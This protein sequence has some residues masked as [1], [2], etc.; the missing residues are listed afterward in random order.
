MCSLFDFIRRR[1]DYKSGF[2]QINILEG[3]AY[4]VLI[5][6]SH[7]SYSSHW[8]TNVIINNKCTFCIFRRSELP[9]KN[10]NRFVSVNC[11]VQRKR[12]N[13]NLTF[14]C[15]FFHVS[16]RHEQVLWKHLWP[17]KHVYSSCSM[18][19]GSVM[20]VMCSC[21]L[22]PYLVCFLSLLSVIIS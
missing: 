21:L 19:Q 15:S 3:R 2:L 7:Y 8:K 5:G 22:C 10:I 1:H 14:L 20:C 17:M 18:C 4:V 16:N 12:S 13:R 6:F 9:C 11:S